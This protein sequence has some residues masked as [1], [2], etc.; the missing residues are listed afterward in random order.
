MSC[1]HRLCTLCL[2]ISCLTVC[3]QN[4]V[5]EQPHPITYSELASP[6]IPLV[7]EN[8]SKSYFIRHVYHNQIN[9]GGL[10]S[11][12]RLT[13]GPELLSFYKEG[14]LSRMD[15][16]KSALIG[17]DTVTQ[18]T[19]YINSNAKDSRFKGLYAT[20]PSQG[21]IKKLSLPGFDTRDI[22]SF[23]ISAT[24]D[25]LIFSIQRKGGAGAEDLYVSI[26][27]NGKWTRPTSLGVSI[28]TS[29]AE[30]SPFLSDDTKKLFFSSNGHG[31]Y[32]Q[33]DIF[34]A[35][36]LYD[37]W[38]VWSE[39]VNLGGGVNSN[40]YEAYLSIVEDSLAYFFSEVDGQGKLWTT[41]VTTPSQHNQIKSATRTRSYLTKAEVQTWLG[42]V[43]DTTLSFVPG[44]VTLNRDSQELL[45]FVAN[46]M[47]DKSNV[48]INISFF[49]HSANDQ[50][51]AR[52][53]IVRNYLTLLGIPK[54]RIAVQILDNSQK[55]SANT[56]AMFNFFYPKQ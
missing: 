5:F 15:K 36:R 14:P 51:K 34:V 56:D 27:K 3:G 18:T 30:I 29:G 42:T 48:H 37:S 32:G 24:W 28:N 23:C 41:R 47:V 7:S 39:P 38:Q 8:S 53:V 44:D 52:S 35:E 49:A 11:K 31:G 9:C 4:I 50:A 40:G 54:E 1:A 16:G 25:I 55:A 45:W 21:R 12:K 33:G 17:T 6:L 2:S 22:H 43:V 19:Y 46:Q 10:L 20:T 26:S 13:I